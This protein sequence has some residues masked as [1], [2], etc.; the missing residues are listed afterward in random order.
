M[1][2][3]LRVKG[4]FGK[5]LLALSFVSIV[6]VL[7]IGWHV[8]SIDSQVLQNEM[9]DKQR[10]VAQR[11]AYSI[12]EEINRQ[13]QFFSVF[14]GLHVDFEEHPDL[15]QGDLDYLLKKNP[16]LSF[17]SIFNE[18]GKVA[19]TAGQMVQPQASM[20]D[21]KEMYHLCI[22]QGK[23]YI[24]PVQRIDENL[25]TFMA[26][27]VWPSS[28]KPDV[29]QIVLVELNMNVLEQLLQEAYF[30][31]MAA[32]IVSGEGNLMAAYQEG[33]FLEK[34]QLKIAEILP[35]FHRSA[36]D[37]ANTEKIKLSN[38]TSLLVSQA[39]VPLIGWTVFVFQPANVT[40]ILLWE[41]IFHSFW[42]VLLILLIVAAFVLAVGYWVLTPIIRPLKRL[43][44]VAIRFEREDTYTP[45]EQE[46]IIP[47]N[48]IGELAR[49]F[50]HMVVVLAERKSAVLS[51]QQKL[52]SSN[53]ELERRVRQ[54]TEELNQAMEDLVKAER[55]SAIGQMASII[56]HEIR[57]PLAVISNA[58]RLIKT[59]H[60]P[61][62]PKLIKQFSIIEEEI[63]QANHIIGEV[64]GFARSRDM[65]LSVID[66]NSYVNE[67]LLSFPLPPKVYL[68]KDL[69]PSSAHLKVD[70]EEL[71]QVLRNLISNAA[72][73]MPQ[74]G[75]VTVGSRVGKEVVCI[76]VEDEGPGITE[77]QK[78][79]IFN[80]FFTTKARGTGLGLAVVRKAISRH[81]G[82]LFIYRGKQ[83]GAVFAIY[84]K[85]YNKM[86]DTRYG[87]AS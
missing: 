20:P 10:S 30:P 7:L 14:T 65:I 62:E 84:L 55:L 75:Q 32:A 33:T 47:N 70:A 13:I 5:A 76:Y 36:Q 86:G 74:G 17:A 16:Q 3:P 39:S 82:K 53:E 28:S 6:P 12:S 54:R 24:G 25:Y 68:V 69:D 26:F 60:P 2:I 48:E 29:K 58:T 11:I 57:N 59:V 43:Q 80:P 63:Q 50:L 44:E 34:K 71:K 73:S 8:L 87:E 52:Q 4:L 49:V 9:A 27:P 37:L 40:H 46:L 21:M 1:K 56:S 15:D 77:A 67:V 51:A 78:K 22:A 45:T 66:L 38:G 72:E 19:F 35:Q 23:P 64:L 83:K 81:K 85:I 31:G 79:K 61:T 18:K 41:N 42:H